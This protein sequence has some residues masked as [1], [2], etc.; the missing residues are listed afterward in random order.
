[1][2][3]THKELSNTE[4]ALFCEQMAMILNAGIS[5]LE[6]I[7][8]MAEDI[9]SQ[10]GRDILKTI[11]NEY[12]TGVTFYKALEKSEV[13]PEYALNM[14]KL[15]EESG[16]L[17]EV[18]DSLAFHYNREQAIADGIKSAVTYPFI[19]IGMMA[20][21]I[22]V[23]IIKVLP[24]FQK[25]FE[26]LGSELTG[27]SKGLLNI[28]NVIGN[29]SIVFIGILVLAFLLYLFF[30]KTKAGHVL[31]GKICSGF[32]LTRDLSELIATGRFA[33]GMALTLS[34]GLNI[35]DSLEMSGKLSENKRLNAKIEK[36]KELLEEGKSLPEALSQSKTFNGT[37]CHLVVVG[38][39]TGCTDKVIKKI[40]VAIDNETESTIS[41]IIG[42]LE[43][44]LV[45]ILS[46]IICMILLSVMLPLMGILSGMM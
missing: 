5:P 26:S 31:F 28:G 16:N 24:I 37:Y 17:E 45:I 25:V 9:D 42:V 30:M 18:M 41:N 32:F 22:L 44:T 40:A 38:E 35:E 14:I 29:Y 10:E 43:P 39:K 11:E 19:I 3:E 1:M 21:V 27:L 23:L 8:V 7:T 4:L 15:G 6:G 33:S 13:F 20:V 34:A 12:M 2:A 36:C 46:V